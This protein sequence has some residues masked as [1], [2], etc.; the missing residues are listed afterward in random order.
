MSWVPSSK[1]NHH[2][3]HPFKPQLTKC[4]LYNAPALQNPSSPLIIYLPPTGFHL[5]SSHPP[6]PSY[7]FHPAASVASIN[8]RWN[9]PSS[10]PSTSST[11]YPTPPPS[12]KLLSSHPSFAKHAFPTPLHDISHAYAYLLS[13]LLPQYSPTP[14]S[15][16]N[17]S[18]TG[19]R[20]TLYSSTP[21]TKIIQRPLL[22][23]GSFLGGSL[24]TSLALTESFASK[25]LPT[26]IAGL[27]S[28]NG[29]YAWTDIATSPPPTSSSTSTLNESRPELHSSELEPAFLRQTDWDSK[30]LFALRETLFS[31][32]EATFDSFASPA[33]FFRTAGIAVPKTWP[34]SDSPSEPSPSLPSPS[35]SETPASSTPSSPL[36]NHQDEDTF[37]PTS[38]PSF[39]TDV[40]INK[41]EIGGRRGR[42]GGELELEV[43]RR[44]H[45]K[46]PPK[47]SGLKIPRALFLY[48][49]PLQQQRKNKTGFEKKKDK[50]AKGNK[51]E[52]EEIT[53]RQQAEEMVHLMRR[54]V[55][56]HEFKDRV[57]WDE[58]LDPSAAAEERVQLSSL[59]LRPGTEAEEE[60][61]GR[62]VE[63]LN[64]TL[65]M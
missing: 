28:I 41:L 30:T 40:D 60:E 56:L 25:Q 63:W 1:K 44:A 36:T 53:P 49:P 45:L 19:T 47:D 64:E 26:R 42:D 31:K 32:P 48:G 52:G 46:Y 6:I 33:L 10:S 34:T 37:Y 61:E 38:D 15:Q 55:L 43:S 11:G 51:G 16:S 2:V 12:A 21:S 20:R 13:S 18:L 29:I 22:I 3:L 57:L 35:S 14:P 59:S 39:V 65:E 17:S 4:S 58:D 9:I 54:S 24:A 50:T 5:H 62:A 27:I 23:Y 8:Y 7:L